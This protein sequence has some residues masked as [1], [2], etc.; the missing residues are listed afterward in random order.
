[1]FGHVVDSLSG[2]KKNGESGVS[3]EWDSDG[4]RVVERLGQVWKKM[5]MGL[6]VMPA[7]SHGK[8]RRR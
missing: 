5:E 8:L 6:T 3:G 4:G 2:E 7:V 1:M